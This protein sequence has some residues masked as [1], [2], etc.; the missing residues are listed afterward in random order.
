MRASAIGNDRALVELNQIKN[1]PDVLALIE[2]IRRESVVA[3]GR[4]KI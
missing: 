2:R 3:T 1:D 4:A